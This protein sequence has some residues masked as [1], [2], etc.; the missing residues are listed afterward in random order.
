MV[1]AHIFKEREA[2]VFCFSALQV[3]AKVERQSTVKFFLKLTFTW[4]R[5]W[6][7][8]VIPDLDRRKERVRLSR[9][10][11]QEPRVS[12]PPSLTLSAVPLQH[13]PSPPSACSVQL[14]SIIIYWVPTVFSCVLITVLGARTARLLKHSPCFLGISLFHVKFPSSV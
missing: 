8:K 2:T 7:T 10:D 9:R 4:H 13:S 3:S 1:R 11:K 14:S 12:Y 5:I 6:V